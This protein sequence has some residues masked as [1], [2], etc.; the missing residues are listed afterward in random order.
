MSRFFTSDW[1][2]DHVN[3]I[4]FA[5]RPFHKS[6][7]DVTP[8]HVG[9]SLVPDTDTMNQTL[10]DNANEM[11]GP[12]DEL[13]FIGD[14]AMGARSVSVPKFK[15]LRCRNLFLVPGNHDHVHRMHK[16]WMKSVDLYEDAGFTIMGSQETIQIGRWS[17][18]VCHFPYFGDSQFED[19]YTGLRP[20]DRGQWLIHGHTHSHER[21][22]GRQ[23]HVGVDAWDYR[24]VAET[25]IEEI[26][27][28]GTPSETSE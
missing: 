16:K 1:H 11:V 20:D 17:V 18:L 25:Q 3:I 13:W 9:E 23:I 14:V 19:R 10:I 15:E 24:P 12:D 6:A 28:R 26:I 4:D 22:R 27:N 5:D 8:A 21:Q 2:I 7:F